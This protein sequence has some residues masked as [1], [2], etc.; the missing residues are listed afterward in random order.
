M[1]K[2]F[3]KLFCLHDWKTHVKEKYN[4]PEQRI[5]PGT[6]DWW[7]PVIEKEEYSSVTEVLICKHCGKIKTIKY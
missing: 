1:K 7:I 2:L 3:K 6:E 4:W 5:V